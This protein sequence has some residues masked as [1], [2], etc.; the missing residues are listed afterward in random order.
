M[1]RKMFDDERNVTTTFRDNTSGMESW[2]STVIEEK[3]AGKIGKFIAI[4][5]GFRDDIGEM[6]SMGKVERG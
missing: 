3:L 1:E 2:G 4:L 6:E 5:P